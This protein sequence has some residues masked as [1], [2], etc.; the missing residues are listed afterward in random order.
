M[1]FAPKPGCP[2]CSIASTASASS[3]R[4]PSAAAK[5]PEILW[6]DDNFTVYRENANPVSSKGHIVIVFKCARPL[7]PTAFPDVLTLLPPI[8][9]TSRQYIPWCALPVL[10]NSI[11]A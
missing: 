2:M 8:A 3:P 10:L 7:H 9:Y 11:T 4:S 5:Q 6:R 1:A